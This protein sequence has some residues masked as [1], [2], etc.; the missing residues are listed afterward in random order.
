MPRAPSLQGCK[1]GTHAREPCLD[2]RRPRALRGASRCSH[3]LAPCCAPIS[4]PDVDERPARTGA[5]TS[6]RAVPGALIMDG[7]C[8]ARPVRPVATRRRRAARRP[9]APSAT[10][11]PYEEPTRAPSLCCGRRGTR[12][13]RSAFPASRAMGG[14]PSRK[15]SASSI[16]SRRRAARVDADR[17]R[18]RGDPPRGPKPGGAHE[19]PSAARAYVDG[20]RAGRGDLRAPRGEAPCTPLTRTSW[21]GFWWAT[22]PISKR[23]PCPDSAS[24]VKLGRT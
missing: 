16:T 8:H 24:S 18:D 4:S 14:P 5:P 12:C 15:R 11:P 22:S 13:R 21:C 7:R 9:T 23:A 1:H 10:T 17:Q 2:A 6:R 19:H 20:G 3:P